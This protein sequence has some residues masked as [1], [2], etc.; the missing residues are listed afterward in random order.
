MHLAFVGNCFIFFAALFAVMSKNQ[1]DPGLA[2]LSIAFSLEVS[3]SSIGLERSPYRSVFISSLFTRY[4][5]HFQ[6]ALAGA[7]G[8]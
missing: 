4:S 7:H 1:L 6:S 8:G 3:F 2:G 5:D